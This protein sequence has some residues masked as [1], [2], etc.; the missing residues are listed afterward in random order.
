MTKEIDLHKNLILCIS[1][2]YVRELIAG[3][4]KQYQ[5]IGTTPPKVLEIATSHEINL[6]KCMLS[7]GDIICECILIIIHC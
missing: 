6:L 2:V 7:S 5:K 3:Y 4:F 1:I